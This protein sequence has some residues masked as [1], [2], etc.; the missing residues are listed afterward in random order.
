MKTFING[1]DFLQQMISLDELRKIALL[2]QEEL[3]QYEPGVE[4]EKIKEINSYS[5]LAII[6]SG[7]RRCGKSTLMRQLMRKVNRNRFFNF[8]DSRLVNFEASD[9]PK[10]EEIFKE[11][12]G[13]PQFYFF[14]E[15]QNVA[16]WELFVRWL[17]DNKKNVIITGSNAS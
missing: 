5:G 13:P 7:V 10:L 1:F 16:K 14:D 11:L 3:K 4:R 9:F 6:L 17:V 2:Q 12:P 15:V 8:E